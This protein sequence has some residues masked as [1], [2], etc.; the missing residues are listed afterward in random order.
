MLNFA[1]TPSKDVFIIIGNEVGDKQEGSYIIILKA[2]SGQSL[3]LTFT[4]NIQKPCKVTQVN[5][6]Q[7]PKD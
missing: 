4:L 7:N 5:V 3:E 6:P 2:N 1:N